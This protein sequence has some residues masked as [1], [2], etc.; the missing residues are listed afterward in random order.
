[1]AYITKEVPGAASLVALPRVYPLE[2]ADNLEGIAPAGT[3]I[4]SACLIVEKMAVAVSDGKDGWFLKDGGGV[5]SIA[6]GQS[7]ADLF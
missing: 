7:W 3:P 4:M 2:L 5:K 1:M 6:A